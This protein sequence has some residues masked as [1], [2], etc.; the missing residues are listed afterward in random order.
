MEPGGSRPCVLLGRLVSCSLCFARVSVRR[1]QN[2]CAQ[3][4][5]GMH[6]GL[7]HCVVS[8]HHSAPFSPNRPFQIHQPAFRVGFVA[9]STPEPRDPSPFSVF[10]A[11]SPAAPHR[12]VYSSSSAS[13][14]A[15]EEDAALRGR[16]SQPSSLFFLIL[17][18]SSSLVTTLSPSVT[19]R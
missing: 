8:P 10:P 15:F 4:L 7:C 19:C 5:P 18:C 11:P 13:P 6:Q 17:N 12:C 2:P 3:G 1:R 16:P 14:A 9:L